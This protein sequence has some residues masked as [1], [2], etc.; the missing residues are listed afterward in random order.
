LDPAIE[1]KEEGQMSPGTTSLRDGEDL[2][3]GKVAPLR[4][5]G[6]KVSKAV[7]RLRSMATA[8]ARAVRSLV[9]SAVD[10]VRAEVRS[11][12][13]LAK[14]LFMAT[15]GKD[16]G[17]GFWWL[18]AM[19]AIAVAIGLLVAVLLSPVIGIVAALVVGI[20]MLIRRS[21]SSRSRDTAM[22]GLAN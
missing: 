22:A 15:I 12:V 7:G 13:R 6:A 17:F 20:W 1:V 19:V 5:L 9:S 11:P 2:T 10:W 3:R 8:T 14:S 4:W 21:R 16:R 18:M